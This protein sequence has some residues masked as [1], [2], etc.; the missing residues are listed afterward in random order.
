MAEQSS[1]GGGNAG[2]AFIV[3]AVVVV[4]AIVA[5][6][7]FARGGVGGETKQVDIDVN[8]PEFSAPAV[9]RPAG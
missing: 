3:G 6:F 1:S 7:V 5:W 4:L 9:P 8:L 2:L